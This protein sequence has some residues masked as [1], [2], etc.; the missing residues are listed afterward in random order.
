MD[1]SKLSEIDEQAYELKG[2]KFKLTLQMRE[3]EKVLSAY[4]SLQN[5]TPNPTAKRLVAKC[6]ADVNRAEE[7]VW[8]ATKEIDNAVKALK[9]EWVANGGDPYEWDN[10]Y[11]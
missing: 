10:A 8:R 1:E 11:S 7:S 9:K 6:V 4:K 5:A 2:V 3:L